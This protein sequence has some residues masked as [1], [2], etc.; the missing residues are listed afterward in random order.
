MKKSTLRKLGVSALVLAAAT[1][2]LFGIRNEHI[3]A[4]SH[5]EAPLI[6]NDPLA[7]NTDLYAFRSPDDTNTVTIIANYIPFE[8]PEGGP[9]WYTFGENIRYEIHIKNNATTKG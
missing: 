2:I 6:S 8:L 7:D 4:S 1:I 9:N 3:T 5:R